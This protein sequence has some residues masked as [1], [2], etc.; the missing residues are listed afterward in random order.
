[1]K[2]VQ[3]FTAA[4]AKFLFNYPKPMQDIKDSLLTTAPFLIR[5]TYTIND[6]RTDRHTIE[7]AD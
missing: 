5:V 2:N 6:V 1:M 7:Y 3:N 4:V